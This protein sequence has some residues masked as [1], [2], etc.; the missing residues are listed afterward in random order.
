MG[1]TTGKMI[2]GLQDAFNEYL[3]AL[4]QR[5]YASVIRSFAVNI[6]GFGTGID[7]Y[8][9]D[10]EGAKEM[11]QREFEQAPDTLN[12]EFQWVKTNQFAADSGVVYALTNISLKVDGHPFVFEDIRLSTV[13]Q[14]VNGLWKLEHMHLSAPIGRQEEGESIPLKELEERNRLLEKTVEER[15]NDLLEKQKLL[16]KM[17]QNKN[18]IFSIIAHDLRSP[19]NSL[20]GLTELLQLSTDNLS[21]MEIQKRLRFINANARNI[22]R[23]VENLLE[24]SIADTG[25]FSYRPQSFSLK[26]LF[27]DNL[28][29]FENEASEKNIHF[30]SRHN[31]LVIFGDYTILGIVLRNLVQN[32]I[33][34][35]YRGG[36]IN[37]SAQKKENQVQ[38]SVQDQGIGMDKKLIE[39]IFSEEHTPSNLGTEHEKGTGLGLNSC[40]KLLKVHK[41]QLKFKSEPN[42]GT[43]AEIIIDQPGLT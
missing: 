13:F 6:G 8:A 28:E 20:L 40:L 22:Y 39:K 7:E 4:A 21:R 12:F 27:N 34:F 17:I 43:L 33:K 19:F 16:E 11:Y 29:I 31:N 1:T 36:V 10:F 41:G 35:S 5:D 15:T 23:V 38:I 14:H 24:W 9:H 32:A 37:I 42:K 26:K 3:K 30:K 18:R 2:P 25:S